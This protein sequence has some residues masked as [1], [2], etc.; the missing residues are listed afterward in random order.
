LED[1]V[2]LAEVARQ[3]GL[4]LAMVA[5]PTAVAQAQSA[6]APNSAS[7][8]G[9]DP[10]RLQLCAW[11]VDVSSQ[12]LN[13]AAPDTHT[14]YWLQ[15]YVMGPNSTVTVN[16]TYPFARYFS[17]TAYGSDGVPINDVS[18][19]DAQIA[20]NA[21]SVN[22]FTTANAPTNPSQRQYAVQI[23]PSLGSTP[24]TLQGLPDGQSSGIG[25]LIYRVYLSDKADEPAG[26]V[27]LPNV[28]VDGR[29]RTT[30][31]PAQRVSSP[32]CSGQRS[33]GWWRRM[34]PTRRAS[35]VALHSSAA[36]PRCRGFSRIPTTNTCTRAMTGLPAA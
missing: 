26:E 13:I 6:P 12:T 25:F 16:G 17:F 8:F 1:G 2:P 33:T 9:L 3:Q 22:P 18:L 32:N 35:P 15:P 10:A 36:L 5:V 4:Q 34:H 30:C 29:P 11:I 19:Y 23:K 27:P 21:G 31:T 20:P 14:H 7:V 28:T 24:N